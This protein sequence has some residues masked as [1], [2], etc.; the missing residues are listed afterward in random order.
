MY[1]REWKNLSTRLKKVTEEDIKNVI[2]GAVKKYSKKIIEMNQNQLL[3]EGSDSK[4]K[5]LKRYAAKWYEAYK[6][7][8]NPAGVTDLRLKGGFYASFFV[9]TS[10]YPVILYA[11]DPKTEDLVNKY[12]ENIFG[13]NDEHK[14]ILINEYIKKEIEEY[15]SAILDLR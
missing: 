10:K 4:G 13:L 14:E 5:K 11:S 7:T 6:M 2:L 1:F 3:F 12:G 8:L 9:E 15:F